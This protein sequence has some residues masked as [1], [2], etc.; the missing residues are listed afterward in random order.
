MTKHKTVEENILYT[1]KVLFQCLEKP[2]HI[3]ELFMIYY[4]VQKK[5]FSAN[6]EN[7]LFSSLIFLYSME[8]I[9]I[10]NHIIKKVF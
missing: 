6:I 5:E 8:K 9:E 10:S 2:M 7:L 1:S 3:D 4:E